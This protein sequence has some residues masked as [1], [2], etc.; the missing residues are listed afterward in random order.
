[1]RRYFNRNLDHEMLDRSIA[2][3]H[4]VID[5]SPVGHRTFGVAVY[6][7]SAGQTWEIHKVF[8]FLIDIMERG[9]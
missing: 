7:C 6:T 1:M 9:N 2:G 4:H 3:S 5:R 8:Q